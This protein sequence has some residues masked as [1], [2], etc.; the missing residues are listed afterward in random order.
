MR[1]KTLAVCDNLGVILPKVGPGTSACIRD[2]D[3]LLVFGKIARVKTKI[4]IPPIKWEKDLQNK[5][6]WGKSST[7][8]ATDA[9]QV[10]KP[11]AISKKASTGLG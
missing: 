5:M 4:P 11:L 8:F 3:S 7:L 10:V 6:E 2:D 9:P 1:Y